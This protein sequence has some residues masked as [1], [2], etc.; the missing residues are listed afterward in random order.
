MGRHIHYF[1]AHSALG[2]LL[3]VAACVASATEVQM[4]DHELDV[5]A[6][7]DEANAAGQPA[8]TSEF[9]SATKGHKTL[10]HMMK[11]AHVASEKVHQ[12]Q[13]K[14]K[15][16]TAK[17]KAENEKVKVKAEEVK[18]AAETKKEEAKQE[19]EQAKEAAEEKAQ[20]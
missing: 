5:V 15:A 8:F 6:F 16:A 2:L 13:D 20:E 19:A 12:L 11:F 3:A 18:Q 10:K 7:V 9:D 4:I 14:L 1:M 17:A